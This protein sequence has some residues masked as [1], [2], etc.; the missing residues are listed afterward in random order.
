M[1]IENNFDSL[2]DI[3]NDKLHD[4]RELIVS[5]TGDRDLLEEFDS[6]KDDIEFELNDFDETIQNYKKSLNYSENMKTELLE[7][8]SENINNLNDKDIQILEFLSK[9]GFYEQVL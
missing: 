7:T 4:I 3:I 1:K 2:H 8:L 5:Y 9:K 6:V